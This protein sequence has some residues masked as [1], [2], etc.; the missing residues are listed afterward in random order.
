M[1]TLKITSGANVAVSPEN[2]P[3]YR[4][5]TLARQTL[6]AVERY[7]AL[8]GVQEDYEKWLVEY[9]KRKA[10]EQASKG[11]GAST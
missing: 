5:R 9:R 2:M 6:H 10:A 1:Q 7:F 8:P 3:D 4:I 11:K